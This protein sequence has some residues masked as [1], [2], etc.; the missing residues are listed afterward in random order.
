[1]SNEVDKFLEGNNIVDDTIEKDEEIPAEEKS[2]DSLK[3]E[4]PKDEK[5]LP[6]NRDPKV[7][8]FI[9]KEI[10][11]ALEQQGPA[12]QQFV[13][14]TVGEEDEVLDVLT[15]IIGNDTPEKVSAI[16]DFKKVLNGLEEKGAEKAL[17]EFEARMQAEKEEER[18]AEAELTEAFANIED[19]YEVDLT[20]NAP[21][22]RKTRN[23]FID[24]VKKIA[25]KNEEGEVVDYPDFNEAFQVFQEMRKTTPQPN[26]AKDL[27]SR[28]MTRSAETSTQPQEKVNWD[29][30]NRLFDKFN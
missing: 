18:K 19:T 20:S 25:P 7:Q 26:R 30:V 12:E 24:F 22:A 27:A 15:R 21:M 23:E 1:M 10:K 28:S 5:P 13:K 29:V 2:E 17:R 16:K 8:R 3:E 9:E 6:F 14:E 4:E 11:K